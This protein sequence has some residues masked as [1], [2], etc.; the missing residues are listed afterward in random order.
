MKPTQPVYIR[1]VKIRV[2]KNNGSHKIV[3]IT[4]KVM[5][6]SP[7]ILLI[8]VALPMLYCL[9]VRKHLDIKYSTHKDP[10][11][12]PCTVVLV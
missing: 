9:C 11:L 3:D 1:N 10:V 12:V 7:R 2:F 6:T 4:D 5:L 8:N